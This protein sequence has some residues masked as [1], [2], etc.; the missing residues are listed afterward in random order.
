MILTVNRFPSY[1]AQKGMVQKFLEN[2]IIDFELEVF[3]PEQSYYWEIAQSG[4]K[5]VKALLQERGG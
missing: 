2:R 1:P 5:Q 4:L 3:T